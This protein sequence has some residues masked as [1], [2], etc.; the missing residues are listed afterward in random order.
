MNKQFQRMP[1]SNKNEFDML[2]EIVHE[3]NDLNS[4][5]ERIDALIENKYTVNQ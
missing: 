5:M 1:V 4:Y 2:D 3:C